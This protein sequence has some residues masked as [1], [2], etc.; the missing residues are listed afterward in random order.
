MQSLAEEEARRF[1]LTTFLQEYSPRSIRAKI[2]SSSNAPHLTLLM[3]LPYPMRGCTILIVEQA[4]LDFLSDDDGNCNIF[5]HPHL[6]RVILGTQHYPSFPLTREL[7]VS[8]RFSGDYLAQKWKFFIHLA[9]QIRRCWLTQYLALGLVTTASLIPGL[10]WS[11]DRG[12][13]EAC[14]SCGSISRTD[15]ALPGLAHV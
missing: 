13:A 5:Q 11:G 9:E 1:Y 10:P 2:L 7:A 12:S 3:H 4:D 6:Q 8:L 15:Q 14:A